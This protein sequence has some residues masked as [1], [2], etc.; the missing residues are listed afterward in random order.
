M[1]ILAGQAPIAPSKTI[2][3]CF[4]RQRVTS[5]GKSPT[6][7]LTFILI[8]LIFEHLN[9]D[10][11]AVVGKVCISSRFARQLRKRNRIVLC[12]VK[13]CAINI[14]HWAK[15]TCKYDCIAGYLLVNAISFYL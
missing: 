3:L 5:N 13:D 4:H 7:E 6:G 2:V 12:L 1:T 11:S 15:S 10:L 8:S 14:S 9:C